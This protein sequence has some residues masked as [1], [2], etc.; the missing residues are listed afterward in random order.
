MPHTASFRI[1]YDGTALRDHSMDVRDLAP[2]LLSLG[3]LLDRTNLILNGDKAAVRLDVRA[4]DKGSFEV[5]LD[6]TQSLYAQA[7]QFLTGEFVE[8]ALNM[9]DLIFGGTCGLFALYRFL[10]GRKPERIENLGGGNVRLTI[11]G[12][13]HVF[14]IKLL[15]LYEDMAARKAIE[16]VVHPLERD[17]IDL[18]LVREG[19][20]TLI[21]VSKEERIWF[22][23]HPEEIED[24]LLSD[25]E[26]EGVFSIIAPVFKD[27][28]KWRLSDG[29]SILNVS[30][31]DKDF[32][33]RVDARRESFYK[34][35][36][37]RCRIR[38]RQWQTEGGLK[39]EH[40]VLNVVDHI[41]SGAQLKLFPFLDSDR[42]E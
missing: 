20:E 38:T 41:Q 18:F 17:G 34:G 23:S 8:S 25:R 32:L 4:M 1:A 6:I 7:A 22:A 31:A 13:S 27:D 5:L 2:A 9:K 28:N 26:Y 15:R 16:D 10:K 42:T 36:L 19:T 37:L 24:V 29:N 35:D 3:Q 40:E 21:G 30:I 14:P 39:T 11:E 12:E 33:E